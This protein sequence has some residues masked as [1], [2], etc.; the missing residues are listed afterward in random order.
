M[1]SYEWDNDM[2]VFC[3]YYPKGHYKGFWY[4]E[5]YAIAEVEQLNRS[6]Q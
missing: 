4:T 6:Y 2:K 5:E 3:V 1:Y